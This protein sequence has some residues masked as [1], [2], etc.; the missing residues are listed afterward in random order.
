MIARVW[1][2]QTRAE[3]AEEYAEYMR[4]TGVKAHRAT[5]GN[6]GSMIFHRVSGEVAD[7]YVIS[8]W[9][10]MD[11]ISA[12]AGEDPEVAVY[13]PEDERYLLELE[14]G[15]LHYDVPAFEVG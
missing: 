5:A 11:A 2:G 14:P 13:F 9:E 8:L 3:H 7:F 12:F 4:Q 15:C 1:H 6:R 10:S